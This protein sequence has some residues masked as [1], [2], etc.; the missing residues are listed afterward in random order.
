MT[1]AATV[2]SKTRTDQLAALRERVGATRKRALEEWELDDARVL[3]SQIRSWGVMTGDM[4]PLYVDPAAAADSAWGTLIA[5]PGIITCYEQIDPE[6][7]SLPGSFAVLTSARLSWEGPIRLGDIVVP[8][9]TIQNVRDVTTD[10][11]A[12]TIVAQEI[13]TR[14]ATN[15][16]RALGSALLTW[17]C[18]E[19]GSA[20]QRALFGD[21]DEAH[22]WSRADI[23]ALGEEYKKETPRTGKQYFDDVTVGEALQPVLK[24]PTTR[25]KYLGRFGSNWYWGHLQGWEQAENRPE[26]FF[27]NENH[28]PEPIPAIDWVHHRAQRWAGLP[29]ALEGNTERVHHLSHLILNWVGSHGF[30]V[31]MDL[32]FPIQNMVGD[33]TRSYATVTAKRTEGSRGIV[34]LDVWQENQLGQRITTGTAEVALPTRAS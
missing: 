5:P 30:P 13:A 23:E 11:A 29:G 3:R 25:T 1:T 10:A 24:G 28:A 15:D 31:S 21:R 8:E 18:Y 20:S 27:E 19:R 6:T 16:G 9:T 26:L 12:G 2:T 33:V 4:R 34:S 14:V 22:M 32:A 7:D 17:N